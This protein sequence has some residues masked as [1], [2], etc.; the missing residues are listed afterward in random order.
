LKFSIEE[1]RNSRG[2]V[3]RKKEACVGGQDHRRWGGGKILSMEKE[4][5]VFSGKATSILM[6]NPVG[7]EKKGKKTGGGQ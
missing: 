2:G 1:T 5:N 7:K 3:Q 4:G 6:P